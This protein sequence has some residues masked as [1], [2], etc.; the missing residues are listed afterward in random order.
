MSLEKRSEKEKSFELKLENQ[1][2]A[3]GWK[4]EEIDANIDTNYNTY[5]R[6]KYHPA[7]DFNVTKNYSIVRN[8]WHEGNQIVPRGNSDTGVSTFD[9]FDE[10]WA[11]AKIGDKIYDTK[12]FRFVSKD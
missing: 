6:T 10:A 2:K 5:E 7:L 8:V 12:T 11:Q 1:I 4:A 3:N 9:N